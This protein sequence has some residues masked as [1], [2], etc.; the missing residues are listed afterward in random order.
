VAAKVLALTGVDLLLKP[1]LLAEARAF[2]LENTGGKPYVSPVPED[3]GPPLPVKG[4]TSPDGGNV[5]R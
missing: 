4:R 5:L 3:Q 2:F 1:E